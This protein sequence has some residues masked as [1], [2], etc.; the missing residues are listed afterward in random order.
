MATVVAS[1][2]AGCL[3]PI[4][5][6]SFLKC[7]LCNENYDLICANVAETYFDLSMTAEHRNTWKCQVCRCKEPKADNTNTPV[8]TGRPDLEDSLFQLEDKS[9]DELPLHATFEHDESVK[10]LYPNRSMSDNVT[11]RRERPQGT[12]RRSSKSHSDTFNED[13]LCLENV[14][15]VLREELALS[16]TERMANTISDAVSAKIAGPLQSAITGLLG[17]VFNLEN[18]VS[19]L[20]SGSPGNCCEHNCPSKMRIPQ[21]LPLGS[22]KENPLIPEEH[23]DRPTVG[24]VPKRLSSSQHH[25]T[26]TNIPTQGIKSGAL[27]SVEIHKPAVTSD[28]GDA[29]KSDTNRIRLNK[30]AAEIVIDNEKDKDASDSSDSWM[31]V[32]RKRYRTANGRATRGSAIAGST[33]LEASEWFRRVHLFFVKQGTTVE[34]VKAH[35]KCVTGSEEIKVESLKPRGPYASFKLTVPSKL[36]NKVMAPESWPQDVC[37][38]PWSQPFRQKNEKQA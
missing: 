11:M 34:Q 7:Y 12:T 3:Q 13:I 38:K 10:I 18:M 23:K 14:R 25:K 4:A 24:L 5:D 21:N 17:R 37:V 29:Q 33:Q 9:S 27:K 26:A 1:S 36:L 30:D 16:V 15:S 28:P 31:E 6:G 22:D 19:K 35:L 8:R 32:N 20:V 2:C